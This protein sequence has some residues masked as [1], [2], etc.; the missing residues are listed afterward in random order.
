MSKKMSIH[1]VEMLPAVVGI[2]Y[3]GF[4]LF[5]A[6]YR[7]LPGVKQMVVHLGFA[8]AMIFSN[9]FVTAYKERKFFSG[10]LYMAML[11]AGVGISV[12][13]WTAVE[14]ASGAAAGRV[15]LEN[16]IV[17]TVFLAL[18]L[19]ATHNRV[20][21]GLPIL[22]LLF[23]AY[24]MLGSYLPQP[25]GHRGY[26]VT[27]IVGN[28]FLGTD[29]MW[30]TVLQA[31][32]VLIAIFIVFG[33][34]LQ[35]IRGGE[36]M[37]EFAQGLL[38][39][40]N[41][42]P[43]KVAVLASALFGSISGSVA[44]NVVGTGTVTI[45]LMKKTGFEP[46]YAAAVEAIAS[47]GGQL[48]P[49]VMGATAFILADYCG[50]TYGSLMVLAIVPAILYYFHLLLQVHL[51]AK[52]MKLPLMSRSEMPDIKEVVRWGGHLF[53]PIIV[54]IYCLVFSNLSVPRSAF[55]G[56]LSG[57]LVSFF[58]KETLIDLWKI[59]P[60][61]KGC[62]MGISMIAV[63]CAAAGMIV[64]VFSLTGL[65]HK[66]SNLL[67]LISGNS[68][69]IL[70]IITMI[71]ALILGMGLPTTAAYIILASLVAPALINFGIPKIVAHFFI[72]YF[73]IYANIT[74]PVA[75]GLYAAI[76]IADTSRIWKTSFNALML[77][78]TGFIMP[79]MLLYR[80]G[81]MLKGGIETI[82]L[83]ITVTV[84]AIIVFNIA[85][86][87]YIMGRTIPT[88]IRGILFVS[89]VV[90][91]G[92]WGGTMFDLLGMATAA[93]VLAAIL[94]LTSSKETEFA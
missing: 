1:P 40:V 62:A 52:K 72:F 29:A 6:G 71:A 64:G 27:R 82:L 92:P 49:P 33:A 90:M 89:C 13:N 51:Y 87:G 77:G 9:M 44:A 28:L 39:N 74:P 8:L 23:L 85:H 22:V 50:V 61:L 14:L 7:T 16:A 4:H 53:I 48:M 2:A 94:L 57:I 47:T 18:V 35:L 55:Y 93:I 42:G 70:L 3:V 10:A 34:V 59:A 58:R 41:G 54:I 66:I 60:V 78:L 76:G 75:V 25:Y 73:G 56:I 43:A 32:S 12:Y 17:G 24:A 30:G 19:I 68:M 15:T 86:A 65:G 26:T 91:A 81:L 20:G 5:T 31:S 45:P 38:G 67:I 36:F 88:L 80:E 21:K 46:E 69:M 63:S 37:A 79:Y 84:S 11:I 83:D